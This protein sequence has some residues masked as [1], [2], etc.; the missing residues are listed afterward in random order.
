M[1]GTE[2]HRVSRRELA[3]AADAWLG[4]GRPGD[5]FQALM[6]LGRTTCRPIPRCDTCPLAATCR[7]LAAGAIPERRPGRRP[8]YAGSLREVRGAVLRALRGD[9]G[10]RSTIGALAS[11][12]GFDRAR[13]TDSVRGLVA[14]GVVAAGPAALLGRARGRVALPA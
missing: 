2:P 10:G 5:V 8:A 3:G 13:V 12:T 11:A 6:D 9:A 1:L 14:D 4:M 7:F